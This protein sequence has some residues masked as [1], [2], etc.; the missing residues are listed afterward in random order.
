MCGGLRRVAKGTAHL[1]EALSIEPTLPDALFHGPAVGACLAA[2]DVMMTA[3]MMEDEEADG[4][5]L[6]VEQSRIENNNAS[7]RQTKV[8]QTHIQDRTRI[9]AAER[10]PGHR[11]RTVFLQRDGR[12]G[13]QFV[14]GETR[15][16]TECRHVAA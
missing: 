16:Q 15:P 4:V 11:K 6:P 10:T 7:C 12:G 3:L 13:V 8:G 9:R 2:A 1:R 14:R 5:R